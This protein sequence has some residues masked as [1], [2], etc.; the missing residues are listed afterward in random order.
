MLRGATPELVAHSIETADP[1]PGGFGFA[2]EL[3]DGRLVRDV[4]GRVPLFVED[5][6]DD[7]S[8]DPNELAEPVSF[9]AGRVRDDGR[10]TA[11]WSLPD[12]GSTS[13]DGSVADLDR[14]IAR[15]VDAVDTDGLALGFSGGVDSALLAAML[16][17]PLYSVGFEGSQDLEVARETAR[18]MDCS[19]ETIEIDHDDLRRLVPDVASAVRR[20]NAMDVQIAIPLTVLSRTVSEQGFERLALGQ[21]A[22]ELFGG[23][24]KIEKAPDDP[25]VEAAT[26]RTA[27]DELL[28]GLPDGLERDALAV[29]T[30]GVEPVFPYLHDAVI[31]TA[32]TLPEPELVDGS[33][34]KVALRSVAERHLPTDVANR[35]KKAMQ[36]GTL[37]SRE[38]DR[39]AR[40]A[41]FKRRMDD[42]VTRYVESLVA[43]ES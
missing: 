34:R 1:F 11:V 36:Y 22:D 42:H 23:Y 43:D 4:L 20:T 40:Q 30:A 18:L 5:D 10:T 37:V 16:D 3:P 38:L 29:Q 7:W 33:R 39:L 15:A 17:V 9:P 12:S 31:E 32:L 28:A 27:R 8:F 14:A 25:R 35:P 2:G 19:I 24:A 41:G 26:V 13:L 21:G 6:G